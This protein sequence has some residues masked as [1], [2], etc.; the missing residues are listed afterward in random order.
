[1][2]YETASILLAILSVASAAPTPAPKNVFK[3]PSRMLRGREVPQEHSHNIFLDGVRV[4]LALNN[5]NDIQDPIFGLLGNAAA[6]AG[7]GSIT[8]LDCLHQATA[9]QAFTNA[10]AAGNI[11]GMSDSL[12]YAA[13]ERNTGS[14][15]LASVICNETA[16]NPE[17]A[18]IQQHQD[19]ASTGA[20]ATNKAIVLALAQQ[21]ASIGANP[22]DALKSGTFAPGT[23]GDPTAA[24]NTCDVADDEPGCIFTQNL[25]VEDATADE[26]TAAVAGVSAA[27]AS[28]STAAVSSGSDCAAAATVTVTADAAVATSA[29]AAT[30]AAAAATT[31]DAASVASGTN[32]Q[33]F[34]GTLGGAAPPVIQSSGDRPFEVNG[35]TFVNAA[36]A[37]QRSCS[38]QNNACSD[39]ANAGTISGGFRTG[40]CKISDF[41]HS[42]VRETSDWSQSVDTIVRIPLPMRPNLGKQH[43]ESAFRTSIDSNPQSTTSAAI[44]L[45]VVF[46]TLPT[47][48]EIHQ[49][50]QR[51]DRKCL[52]STTSKTPHKGVGGISVCQPTMLVLR[53]WKELNR[54]APLSMGFAHTMLVHARGLGDEH[55]SD[56]SPTFTDSQK[57]TLEILALAFS[58]VSIASAILAFYWFM[59]MQRTFRHDLIM[60]L[61]QSDMFKSLWLMIYPVVVFTQ[62][63]VRSDSKLC[64]ALGFFLSLGIEASDFAV[65]MIAFH[66][67]L[68]I[69]RP[70]AAPGEGGLYPYRHV[71]YGLWVVFPTLMASLAFTNNGGGYRSE[72]TY[73][74]LPVRP[75]WYRLA[76]SWI[77]RYIIF[78]V[79]L[80]IYVSIYYHV[81]HK[82]DTFSKEET[83]RSESVKPR[84]S[85]ISRRLSLPAVPPLSY[86]GLIPDSERISVTGPDD[87]THSV[88][89]TSQTGCECGA[90]R[91]MWKCFTAKKAPNNSPPSLLSIIET[92]SFTGPS[93]PRPLPQHSTI[94]NSPERAGSIVSSSPSLSRATSWRD[95]F[96]RRVSLPASTTV[97]ERSITKILSVLHRH[98]GSEDES[99]TTPQ[100]ELVD[101]RGQNLALSEIV[102]TREKIQRQLRFLFIYPLVYTGMWIVPFAAHVLMYDDRFASHPPFGLICVATI[103][104]ASQTAIDCWLFSTR[105]KPW[106]HIPGSNGSVLGS[107]RFWSSWEGVSKGRV[108]SALGKSRE[109]VVKDSRVPYQRR[110]VELAERRSEVER[111]G[112]NERKDR[113]WWDNAGFS[114]LEIHCETM[115]L[116]TEEIFSPIESGTSADPIRGTI[117]EQHI[118]EAEVSGLG[119]PEQGNKREFKMSIDAT[120]LGT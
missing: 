117:T 59:K 2:K 101:S 99:T 46:P 13:L 49:H 14:V 10:K 31:T 112:G 12:I 65:L 100:L 8:N 22:Q 83:H 34:T 119:T 66:T 76:L 104:F 50:L 5:P 48:H 97:P 95:N 114:P 67:A 18:A 109:D 116:V 96:V 40:K 88:P 110:D 29:P 90:H 105:E 74:Y 16:V 30:V 47:A 11:T 118:T 39:A 53:I 42:Q 91:F 87:R 111:P 54:M 38:V 64:Q 80:G 32:I 63:S 113:S 108:D 84:P 72:G 77:P 35:A 115:T 26:I 106:M 28:N 102:R 25:L 71:A 82:F 78:V 57:E 85:S 17:I 56:T 107:L 61:I 68:Y 120:V 36:A 43:V 21:L 7:A 9:D 79:I 33:T 98:S 15:G 58:T 27:A 69:F 81:R 4:N 62:G 41:T 3:V 20:A 75:F 19:P 86:H 23:I 89:T 1:M 44:A 60:L 94:T 70:G 6:A 93:T 45:S 103:F 51:S 55:S 37:L 92:D 24:G 73:C 52:D